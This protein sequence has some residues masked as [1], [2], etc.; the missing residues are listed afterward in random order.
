MPKKA[1]KLEKLYSEKGTDLNT[2]KSRK[3]PERFLGGSLRSTV[4]M[5]TSVLNKRTG[6]TRANTYEELNGQ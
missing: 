2:R 4:Y 5:M 3:G 1:R 6:A